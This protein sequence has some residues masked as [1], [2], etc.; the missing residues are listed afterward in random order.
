MDVLSARA[1]DLINVNDKEGITGVPAAG[2]A[3]V[4]SGADAVGAT[5]LAV[6]TVGGD[7]ASGIVVADV[8]GATC[9][10]SAERGAS[11]VSPTRTEPV[12]VTPIRD[13]SRP[14][15]KTTGEYT[16]ISATMASEIVDSKSRARRSALKP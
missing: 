2:G 16:N 5:S 9:P 13:A 11:N 6:A 15:S 1:A 14:L 3:A 7:N 10:T 4:G 12:M 8:G